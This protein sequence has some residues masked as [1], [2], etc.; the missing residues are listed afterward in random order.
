[1]VDGLG[2][3]DGLADG[4]HAAI[5]N[6]LGLGS[7]DVLDAGLLELGVDVVLGNL[8]L[9]LTGE[10]VQSQGLTGN[11]VGLLVQVADELL[12]GQTGSGQPGVE[13]HAAGS[14]VGQEVLAKLLKDGLLVVGVHLVELQTLG[15]S[16]DATVLLLGRQAGSLVLLDLDLDG[17]AHSVDAVEAKVGLDELVG[18]LGGVADLDALDGDLDGVGLGLLALLDLVGP[19]DGLDVVNV[20]ADQGLVELLRVA[21]ATGD[22]HAA[23]GGKVVGVLDGL[24]VDGDVVLGLDGATLDVL[25]GGTVVEKHL[26][27]VVNLRL[28]DLR[29][30]HLDLDSV[31]GR[32]LGSRTQGELDGVGVVL[33]ILGEVELLVVTVLGGD[34]VQLVEDGG[35][36]GGDQVV[37]GLSEGSLGAKCGVDDRTGSLAGAEA[38]EAVLLG[39]ILVGLLN[40]GVDVG[41][42]DGDRSGELGVLD[43]RSGDVQHVPPHTAQLI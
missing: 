10:G 38:R 18:E 2:A 34:D 13:R 20:R 11:V 31:E 28:G 22:E 41:G 3:T 25:E 1:M 15:E 19:G 39:G 27:L 14:E 36:V 5:G 40:R 32:E 24:E 8:N 29:R 43:V 26:D 7:L 17:V 37:G 6:E 4:R 9:E 21:V 42:R 30:G 16:G 12:H 35:L 33:V 23:L